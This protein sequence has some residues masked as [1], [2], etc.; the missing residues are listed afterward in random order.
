VAVG[1]TGAVVE[2]V[3]GG[4]P[5]VDDRGAGAGG[6]GALVAVQA[7]ARRG[8]CADCVGGT[9]GAA[10]AA[11]GQQGEENCTTNKTHTLH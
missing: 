11:T 5:L 2:V 3:G 1:A 10:A 8:Q 4:A 9:G 7:W 6:D